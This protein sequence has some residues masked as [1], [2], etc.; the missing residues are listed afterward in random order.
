MCGI[1]GMIGGRWSDDFDRAVAS[2][3]HRGP[4]DQGIWHQDGAWLGHCRLAVIDIEGGHQPMSTDDGRYWIVFNGEIYNFQDLRKRLESQAV[5]FTTRSDTEVLLKGYAVWGGPK[6]LD[7]LDGMFAF[8]IWDTHRRKLFAARDRFGIKPFYYSCVDGF[9]FGSTLDPFWQMRG[10]PRR[11]NYEALR[12]YLACQSIFA[13][14][15]ILQDVCALGPAGWLEWDDQTRSCKVGRYWDIPSPCDKAMSFSDLVDATDTAMRQSIKRQLVADVPVGAFL[16]GGID[17]SLMVYYMND[18]GSSPV[19]TFSVRFA[20]D[21]RYD[22]SAYAREVAEQLGC[23]HHEIDSQ[24]IDADALTRAIQSLDQPLA[25]PA[26][27]PTLSLSYH[28][29]KDVT[30]AISGDGGDELFG[31]YERFFQGELQYPPGRVA[32]W[33]NRA[34]TM[35]LLPG[36]VLRRTLRGTDRVLW[37]RVRLGPYPA[38]RKSMRN[39]L[40]PDAWHACRPDQTL[41]HWCEQV[42]RWGGKMDTDS[43]MRGDLWTYL[44]DNCLVKTDRA[45]MAHS[46]E[47][48][49][50]ILGNDV[51]DLVLPQPAAVKTANGTKAILNTLAQRYLPRGV[52]DRPKHGFSVPLRSYFQGPWQGVC[53]QWVDQADQLAPFLQV[54]EVR[55]RWG[56]ASNGGGDQRVMYTLIVLLAWLETHPLDG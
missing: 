13:P 3:A 8:A 24:E 26:Y 54:R 43:L 16:S 36:S 33:L 21:G 32:A 25:D 42:L 47:V 6:L 1:A 2:L 39:V 50:P 40:T 10:F 56:R 29:R 41:G 34:V 11:I 45:S 7:A 52:W 20:Q 53:G 23:E 30:V 15:T 48:R 27:L 44:S 49:V 37:D 19:R 22:E 51:V 14:M 35:G 46:L 4:D 38:G 5:R 12:D 28:T 31:G 55:R 17:S 18:A 9:V